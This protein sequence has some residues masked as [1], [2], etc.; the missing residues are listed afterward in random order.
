MSTIDRK[1]IFKS[2]MQD[3]VKT[4][5]TE[6]QKADFMNKI[7][8]IRD[9]VQ[10]FDELNLF[11]ESDICKSIIVKGDL[12]K[13]KNALADL[14][15][16]DGGDQM[17]MFLSVFI[18]IAAGAIAKYISVSNDNIND[19]VRELTENLATCEKL[20]KNAN[21]RCNELDKKYND[22]KNGQSSNTD[23]IKL[24]EDLSKC[25]EELNQS[26][27]KAKKTL[28]ESQAISRDMEKQAEKY[29]KLLVDQD[30]KINNL[31]QQLKSQP[32]IEVF[33]TSTYQQPI[34]LANNLQNSTSS[35]QKK[36]TLPIE[37]F[38]STNPPVFQSTNPP[39]FQ[40]VDLPSVNYL[41]SQSVSTNFEPPYI[42][43][44]QS[45]SEQYESLEDMRKKLNELRKRK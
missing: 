12:F 39:T 43:Q 28:E 25:K 22:L 9:N 16:R 31:K 42:P 6:N 35:F 45:F 36:Q 13:I 23:Q 24:M 41:A 27:Q 17:F 40:T 10:M 29:R 19:R 30:N 14:N 11:I 5:F 4:E 32:N 18:G 8:Q 21:I 3:F 7:Y 38:Q 20:R 33:S 1:S 37:V 44:Q 15:E 26:R 2:Y 34:L